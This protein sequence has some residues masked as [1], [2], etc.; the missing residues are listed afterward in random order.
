[1]MVYITDWLIFFG[2]QLQAPTVYWEGE[3]CCVP[4]SEDGAK[5][6]FSVHRRECCSFTWPS[7]WRDLYG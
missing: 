2:C 3:A 7:P 5:A 6:C 4:Y 1:M